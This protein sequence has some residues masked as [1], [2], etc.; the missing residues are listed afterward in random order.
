MTNEQMIFCV[1]KEH[2]KTDKEQLAILAEWKDEQ[3]AK[4]KQAL[5]DKV[6]KWLNEHMYCIPIFEYDEDES[7]TNYVCANCCDSVEEFIDVFRK[8]MEVQQ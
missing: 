7:P 8:A 2:T 6:C 3:F 1:L 4:E 5:I